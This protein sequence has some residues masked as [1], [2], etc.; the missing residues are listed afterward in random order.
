MKKLNLFLAMFLVAHS[1]FSQGLPL[2][3]LKKAAKNDAQNETISSI[4]I[5][6]ANKSP[7]T[8]IT[9]SMEKIY[10]KYS[11]PENL[12]KKIDLKEKCEL[13][14]TIISGNVSEDLK[15]PN[16]T[17]ITGGGNDIPYNEDLISK[18]Y[19][20]LEIFIKDGTDAALTFQLENDEVFTSNLAKGQQT[21]RFNFKITTLSSSGFS[22][23]MITV[24]SADID[25]VIDGSKLNESQVQEWENCYKNGQCA[26]ETADKNALN[27]FKKYGQSKLKNFDI[28]HV[29][30]IN[31][32]VLK[33]GTVKGFDC[34]VTG[35][36]KST[37]KLERHGFYCE[38]LIKDN[39]LISFVHQTYIKEIPLALKE[40]IRNVQ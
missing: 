21:I 6:D 33:S 29:A 22:T 19:Q 14:T 25:F 27:R 40:K 8:K 39:S 26:S 28:I 17:R 35:I 32:S 12:K 2:G 11:I 4:E 16:I 9:N 7:I 5:L 3:V 15:A 24:A 38:E 37:G 30:Q 23:K 10:L 36:D 34:Y 13:I 1:V 31:S 20:E 18:G